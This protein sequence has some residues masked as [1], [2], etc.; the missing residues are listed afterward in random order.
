MDVLR[1]T[2]A[3][4]F[5]TLAG[6][7]EQLSQRLEDFA[8][9]TNAF[10]SELA[11]VIVGSVRLQ[12]AIT[13]LEVLQS[14]SRTSHVSL[15]L[16]PPD[17]TG[18]MEQHL[19]FIESHIS[20]QRAVVSQAQDSFDEAERLLSTFALILPHPLPP[21]TPHTALGAQEDLD[22]DAPDD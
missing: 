3:R 19:Q 11:A 17:H 21:P 18:P 7:Y 15:A 22:A 2:V 16:V 14:S 6:H 8:Q 5:E 20:A 13:R 12:M 9:K 10:L 1:R 4:C